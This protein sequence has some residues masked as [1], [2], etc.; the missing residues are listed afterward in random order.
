MS[1]K[2]FGHL[3]EHAFEESKNMTP[4]SEGKSAMA[5]FFAGFL[6][7]P[8]GVGI[9]LRSWGDFIMSLGLVVGGTIMATGLGAPI[10]WILCGIWAAARVSNSRKH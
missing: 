8:F 2:H 1:N 5:A 4:V 3:V 7:G 10:F 6:F 9:Y